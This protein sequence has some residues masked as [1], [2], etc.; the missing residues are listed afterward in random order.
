MR[1][2]MHFSKFLVAMLLLCC[3]AC[4]NAATNE[5]I[6]GDELLL[7]DPA[8]YD[9]SC[10]KDDKTSTSDGLIDQTAGVG[11]APAVCQQLLEDLRGR[12]HGCSP[13]F[14]TAHHATG[15]DGVTETFDAQPH[16]PL[17]VRQPRRE[18]C[19]LGQHRA[20]SVLA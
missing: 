17:S 14:G 6:A 18:A 1:K 12:L 10:I 8:E 20:A 11:H 4:Q 16:S 7:C 5:Q 13:L 3:V 2:R 15:L 19:S 9:L